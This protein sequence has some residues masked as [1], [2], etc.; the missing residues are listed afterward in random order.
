MQ[1]FKSKSQ[2]LLI[3]RDTSYEMWADDQILPPLRGR[4]RQEVQQLADALAA[5]REEQQR[6]D[7][8]RRVRQSAFAEEVAVRRRGQSWKYLRVEFK[9]KAKSEK[10]LEL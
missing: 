7:G 6:R 1:Y 2:T 5:P 10:L 8:D 3:I 4:V 9:I